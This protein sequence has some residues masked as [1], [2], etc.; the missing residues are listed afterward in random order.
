MPNSTEQAPSLIREQP[1]LVL[2]GTIAILAGLMLIVVSYFTGE[3]ASPHYHPFFSFVCLNIGGLLSFT[4]GYTFVSEAFFKRVFAQDLSRSLDAKLGRLSL[5]ESIHASGLT[6]IRPSF[7]SASLFAR[8][9]AAS[10]VK[11]FVMRSERFFN[12]YSTHLLN[13]M[14]EGRLKLELIFPDPSDPKLMEVMSR[15][16]VGKDGPTVS[17][18]IADVI[19]LWLIDKLFSPLPSER[20]GQLTL[21]LEPNPP[22]YSAYLF[23]FTELWYIPYHQRDGRQ[24]LPIYVFNPV[25]KSSEL[26]LDVMW[27]LDREQVDLSTM[28]S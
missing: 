11:M 8:I 16:F 9:S 10:D 20:K 15:R 27:S 14:S 5:A 28:R 19:D 3:S 21:R 23:D 7:D 4:A 26:Y 18:S 6:E 25:D 22:F 13:Q 1:Y 17:K 24:T 2:W 12:Q